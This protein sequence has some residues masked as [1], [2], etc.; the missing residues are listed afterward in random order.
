[1]T[2]KLYRSFGG[3]I[4]EEDSQDVQELLY[5]RYG[6]TAYGAE[7]ELFSGDMEMKIDSRN[8]KSGAVRVYHDQPV[9]F[10]V[11]SLI[12]KYEILEA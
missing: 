8:T 1:M 4:S 5:R 12:T 6:A 2:L 9:P 7:I 10:N 11:L 3:F